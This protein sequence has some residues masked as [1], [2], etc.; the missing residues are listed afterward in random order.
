MCLRVRIKS[1]GL[2]YK[3]TPKPKIAKKPIKVIKLVGRTS[4]PSE[5]TPQHGY[6]A[7]FVYKVGRMHKSKLNVEKYASSATVQE[8]LH[9]FAYEPTAY[10]SGAVLLC[11]IPKGATYYEQRDNT[12]KVDQRASNKLKVVKVIN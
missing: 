12:G 11:I 3:T 4:K 8:G 2:R 1:N 5:F 10:S 6:N 9:S 7:G